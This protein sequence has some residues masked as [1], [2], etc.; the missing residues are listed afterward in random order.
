MAHEYY[1]ENHDWDLTL[2]AAW[3]L[4]MIGQAA[5]VVPTGGELRERQFSSYLGSMLLS[6]CAIESFSASVAFSMPTTERF[7]SFDFP[8]YVASRRFW[9]KL[10][11]LCTVVGHDIDKSQG[12]F[13]TIAEMQQ[14]RNLVTHSAPYR[15]E[16][17]TVADITHAPTK[18]HRSLRAQEYTRKVDLAHA[19]KF[20]DAA[21]EYIAFL[22]DA[23]G[24]EPRAM[25]KYT[26]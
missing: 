20:Y 12:L 22:K 7:G 21:V 11:N 8:R 25:A 4:C 24:I 1:A 16:S 18:L 26:V 10:Q 6:F 9:D 19:K 15:I 3:S 17:T 14:W 23:S 5:E 13:Q 2:R